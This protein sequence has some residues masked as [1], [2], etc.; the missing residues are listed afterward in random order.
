MPKLIQHHPLCKGI[1]CAFSPFCLLEQ[2]ESISLKQ[3]NLAVK[4]QR[5]LQRK[6]V[7][8][9][10][11]NKFQHLYAIQQGALKTYQVEPDGK[12]L[13]RGFY[14]AGEILGY[15]AIYTGRT[16]FSAAAL[17]ETIICEIPYSHFLELLHSRPALQE[18]ILHLVSQQLSVG[19]YLVSNSAEQRLAAFLMDLSV[20]LHPEEKKLEF[21]LPMSR[22]DIGNYL[23]LTAETISRIFSRLQHNDI[24]EIDH[25]QIRF[26]K[27]ETLKR[28]ADGFPLSDYAHLS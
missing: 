6:E 7:L 15:E 19:S 10:P 2:E 26:L 13:I 22:Q 27:P 20:R 25:K 11:N 14:F 8:F 28:I 18:H 16:L 12:E 9:L 3:M 17:A 21:L 5:H 1:G 4:R 23:R 24:I